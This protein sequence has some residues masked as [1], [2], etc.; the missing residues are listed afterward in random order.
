MSV[1]VNEIRAIVDC[2]ENDAMLLDGTTETT[3]DFVGKLRGHIKALTSVDKAFTNF[4]VGETELDNDSS[5]GKSGRLDGIKWYASVV[6]AVRWTLDTKALK[7][8]FGSEWYDAR[9]KM[10]TVTTTKYHANG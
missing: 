7:A 1:T 3:I 5:Q 9:C 8:E 2:I 10:Q 4:V 6:Q